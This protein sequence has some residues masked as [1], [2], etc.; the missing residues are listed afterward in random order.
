MVQ[1]KQAWKKTIRG[2]NE[3]LQIGL[4]LRQSTA[5]SNENITL[6]QGIRTIFPANTIQADLKMLAGSTVCGTVTWH[7][8]T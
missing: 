1:V 4:S 6:L 7:I 5:Q 2:L 3:P 8:H